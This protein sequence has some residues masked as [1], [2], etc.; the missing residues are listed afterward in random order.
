MNRSPLASLWAGKGQSKDSLWG[1]SQGSGVKL[2]GVAE[3][4]FTTPVPASGTPPPNLGETNG[5]LRVTD[6][7]ENPR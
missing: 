7:G 2:N 4:V 3:G 6:G 5:N 1:L